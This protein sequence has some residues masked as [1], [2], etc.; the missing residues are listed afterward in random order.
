M[1]SIRIRT[2]NTGTMTNV[3]VLIRHPME[4]GLR[5][6][7]SGRTIPAHFIQEFNCTHNGRSVFKAIWGVAVSKDPYVSFN[8]SNTNT[9]DSVSVS[10]LDN[11]G[12]SDSKTVI[13]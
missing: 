13:I 4:T 6:D 9:G 12:V 7:K 10:W 5:K 11:L 2:K 1:N 8:L 3:K